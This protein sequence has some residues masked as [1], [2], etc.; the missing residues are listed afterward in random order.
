MLQVTTFSPPSAKR[1]CDCRCWCLLPSMLLQTPRLVVLVVGGCQAHSSAPFHRCWLPVTQPAP[2]VSTS[3]RDPPRLLRP[4]GPRRAERRGATTLEGS[5]R[6]VNHEKGDTHSRLH[7]LTHS[8]TRP[9]TGTLLHSLAGSLT[10]SAVR[11]GLSANSECRKRDRQ[12]VMIPVG[13]Y[14][15][16]PSDDVCLVS[17]RFVDRW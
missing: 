8:T 1:S 7:A 16:V 6:T 13:T 12:T 9:G 4:R 15:Y 3:R 17:I 14:D 10:R 11:H 2:I 5:P